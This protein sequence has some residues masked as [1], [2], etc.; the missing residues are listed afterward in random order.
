MVLLILSILLFLLIL[1]IL[2]LLFLFPFYS[3]IFTNG[4]LS[5]PREQL[6][7]EK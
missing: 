1:L 4:S 7:V 3:I 6:Q 2:L 5:E